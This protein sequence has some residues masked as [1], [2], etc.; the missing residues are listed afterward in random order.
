M[1][2]A[3]ANLRRKNAA[4]SFAL[5]N[6]FDQTI[7]HDENLAYS[8]ED[9][10]KFGEDTL[11]WVPNESR[12]SV[13]NASLKTSPLGAFLA[14]E[15]QDNSQ[16]EDSEGDGDENPEN[17]IGKENSRA[18]IDNQSC[19]E[20]D[21]DLYY[22]A[23]LSAGEEEN[24]GNELQA[25]ESQPDEN[26]RAIAKMM[27]LYGELEGFDG[28]EEWIAS[29][30]R[31]D[32]HHANCQRSERGDSK[33]STTNQTAEDDD[34]SS[35]GKMLAL[36]NE[37]EGLEGEEDWLQSSFRGCGRTKTA[38]NVPAEADARV[39]G[40]ADIPSMEQEIEAQRP[41]HEEAD[42][43]AM[44]HAL[45]LIALD[46]AGKSATASLARN[47]GSFGEDSPSFHPDWTATS[48]EVSA[49]A[50]VQTGQFEHWAAR[51]YVDPE[52]FAL[53]RFV[54]EANARAH[55]YEVPG[56]V[57][58]PDGATGCMW[59]PEFFRP[60]ESGIRRRWAYR[61]GAKGLGGTG[62][63]SSALCQVHNAED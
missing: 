8:L 14:G 32:P 59:A 28:E 44:Q 7:S 55:L 22:E 17:S 25:V 60:G 33:E 51:V 37:L 40:M 58:L 31:K 38:L 57:R 61:P 10:A 46:E 52:V 13:A 49:W 11:T 30:A 24:G 42:T 5:V 3:A 27:E 19:E 26:D 21:A 9:Y 23:D 16:H 63:A 43:S 29:F 35:M 53:R 34:D 6:L 48:P 54:L 12:N 47:K 4:S 62:P 15:Y 50:K 20:P 18:L 1:N 39:G 45:A 56:E 41:R 36:Y 2:Q